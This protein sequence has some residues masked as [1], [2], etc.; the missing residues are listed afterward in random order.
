MIGSQGR[1]QRKLKMVSCT[2]AGLIW[3]KNRFGASAQRLL[4]LIFAT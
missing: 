4:S 3:L 1:M 2:R